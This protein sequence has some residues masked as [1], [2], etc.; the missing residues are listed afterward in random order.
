MPLEALALETEAVVDGC[1]DD[2][3][4]SLK[5]GEAISEYAIFLRSIL[6]LDRKFLPVRVEEVIDIARRKLGELV[7]NKTL[8]ASYDPK[9]SMVMTNYSIY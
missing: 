5:W 9:V 7:D 4:L 6:R 3:V 1:V 8:R 2:A